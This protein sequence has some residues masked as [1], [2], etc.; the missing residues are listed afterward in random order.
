MTDASQRNQQVS[1][2]DAPACRKKTAKPA[3]V[4]ITSVIWPSTTIAQGGPKR[5]RTLTN[6][7]RRGRAKSAS[8][9]PFP[10]SPKIRHL[11]F[12]RS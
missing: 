5:L 12:E 9:S 1:E 8:E 3:S 10:A 11:F 7:R 4:W 6:L 2:V